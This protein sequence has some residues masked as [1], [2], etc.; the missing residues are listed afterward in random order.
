[1]IY[2]QT[3]PQNH[4]YPDQNGMI[5]Y[6]GPA[7]FI[8]AYGANFTPRSYHIYSFERMT[9]CNSR[10]PFQPPQQQQQRTFNHHINKKRNLPEPNTMEI[11]HDEE[12]PSNK[13]EKFRQF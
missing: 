2:F 12:I 3:I 7:G 9:D 11:T 1:M 6:Q 13:R 8:D 5:T 4:A 10:M